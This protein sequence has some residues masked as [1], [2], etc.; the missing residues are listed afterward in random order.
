VL[1][2]REEDVDMIEDMMD[3]CKKEYVRLLQTEVPKFKGKEIRLKLLI[4]KTKF[5]SQFNSLESGLPSSYY[6][7]LFNAFSFIIGLGELNC[8]PRMERLYAGT[9]ST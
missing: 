8:M 5:L 2:C 9:L 3:E 7:I 6:Y 1:K 4:N